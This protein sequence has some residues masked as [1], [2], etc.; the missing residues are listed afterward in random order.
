MKYN[1]RNFNIKYKATFKS[2]S[3]N[4][5]IRIWIVKPSDSVCQKIS[6]FFVLPNT[7]CLYKD[8]QENKILYYEFRNLKNITIQINIKATLWKN[9]ISLKRGTVFLPNSSSKLFSQYTK[10]EKFLEQTSEIKKIALQITKN[11]K[12]VLDKISSIFNFVVKNFKYQY[13]IK[14]RGVKCLDLNNLKGDCGEYS[15]LFTSMCR[16][17]KIPARN[18]TG[19]VLFPKQKKISEHG[20]ASVYLKPYGWIDVDTQYASLEKSIETGIKKYLGQRSDY[21]INFTNGFNIPLKPRIPKDFCLDYWNNIGLPLNNVSVQTLQ[22]L[23]FASKEKVIFKDSI[24]INQI[25][26]S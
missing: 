26:K 25:E 3:A 12:S 11:D 5:D 20:W 10:N 22:P 9:K 17:L 6:K 16:I 15:G 23:V 24:K 13:P 1:H 18:N 14:K 8:K 19:F 2:F 4:N 7:K 21:R